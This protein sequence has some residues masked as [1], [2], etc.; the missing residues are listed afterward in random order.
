MYLLGVPL[1]IRVFPKKSTLVPS[2]DHSLPKLHGVT[3][4]LDTLIVVAHLR[5]AFVFED[6]DDATESSLFRHLRASEGLVEEASQPG[7]PHF[8]LVDPP[9][10]AVRIRHYARILNFFVSIRFSRVEKGG[11]LFALPLLNLFFVC[12]MVVR[13]T[14]V[15]YLTNTLFFITVDGRR[16]HGGLVAGGLCDVS[17]HCVVVEILEI[18]LNGFV[19]DG[20]D[21]EEVE[22]KEMING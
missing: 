22:E 15:W 1:S 8:H 10:V 2:L 20:S 19:L 5:I 4:K 18:L 21:M 13:R 11:E 12:S 6:R 14:D 16:Q 7:N 17:R 3:N 9:V